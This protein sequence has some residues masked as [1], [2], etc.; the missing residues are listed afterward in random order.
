MRQ[1]AAFE[2]REGIVDEERLSGVLSKLVANDGV[3][4][5]KHEGAG[6]PVMRIA[7]HKVDQSLANPSQGVLARPFSKAARNRSA[8][9]LDE[10]TGTNPS[11]EA[12][13]PRAEN[14]VA[15]GMRDDRAKASQLDSMESLV[16]GG[17]NGKFVELDQEI[18]A[19]IDAEGS[20]MLV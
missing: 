3:G 17:W 18:I 10:T 4:G 7:S 1:R 6:G 11:G 9:H 2:G 13:R 16:H 14:G 15:L 5:L 12:L 19:L 8:G 20:R